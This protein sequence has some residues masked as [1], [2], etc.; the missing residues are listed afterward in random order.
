MLQIYCG[1]PYADQPEMTL[2][3]LFGSND[4]LELAI[5]GDS[6]AA[7]LGVRS[8]APVSVEW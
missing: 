3:A 8:G 2:I 1:G 7:M 5:V 4:R 6:A